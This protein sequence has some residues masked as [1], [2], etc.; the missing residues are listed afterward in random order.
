VEKNYDVFDS[1][2][3]DF[4]GG[5]GRGGGGGGYGGYDDYNTYDD[6]YRTG[7]AIKKSLLVTGFHIIVEIIYQFY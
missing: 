1:P 6:Y 2:A 7:I 4:G 3:Y 5:G